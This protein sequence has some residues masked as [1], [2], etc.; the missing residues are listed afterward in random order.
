MKE[1]KNDVEFAQW[2]GSIGSDLLE[3]SYE[4]YQYRNPLPYFA[5]TTE[6]IIYYLGQ[7]M[8]R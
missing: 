3:A 5:T 6:L 8:S 1:I 4:E 7:I 2:Y